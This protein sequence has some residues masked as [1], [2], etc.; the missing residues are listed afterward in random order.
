MALHLDEYPFAMLLSINLVRNC[1]ATP[2][3][4]LSGLIGCARVPLRF[5]VDENIDSEFKIR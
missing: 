5:L 3:C 1:F 2:D 4:L